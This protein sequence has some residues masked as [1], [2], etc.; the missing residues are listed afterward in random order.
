MYWNVL[1]DIDGNVQDSANRRLK[2]AITGLSNEEGQFPLS[3]RNETGM[4]WNG[5]PFGILRLRC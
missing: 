5:Q 4:Q 2:P 1:D 3:L